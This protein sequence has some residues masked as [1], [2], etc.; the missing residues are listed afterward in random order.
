MKGYRPSM[1]TNS[2][3]ELPHIEQQGVTG[4]VLPIF[5]RHE[6][7]H[8]RHGWL[9]KGMDLAAEGVEMLS[10]NGAMVRLGV[11]KNMVNAIRYWC[12]AFKVIEPASSV[13]RSQS[14]SPTSFGLN[15]LRD[16]G[17]DPY[18]EDSGSLWLLH[19]HLL[20]P[21]CHAAAWYHA[22]YVFNRVEFT[23]DELFLAML[24][25]ARG[26]FQSSRVAESSLRKDAACIVRMYSDDS[27]SNAS[28]VETIS[29]PFAALRLIETSGDP[30]RFHF[31]VG[32]KPSL[33]AEIIA[34][35]CLDFMS[36]DSSRPAISPDEGRGAMTKSL[37]ALL[38]G[39]GSPGLAFKLTESALYSALESVSRTY[40]SLNIQD[41]GGILQIV[42]T[43]SPDAL[44]SRILGD[45]YTG[46]KPCAD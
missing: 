30:M 41:S 22:F 29:S 19:W 39:E 21:R 42:C 35:V 5:A 25:W 9:K 6:T 46:R 31:N 34:A 20:K 38:Y 32:L 12:R 1:T 17:W 24:E 3:L 43:E 14:F 4:E 45:Y 33:P 28:D 26:R 23:I 37:S 13:A 18:L 7:F 11:G 2:Q 16:A 8:P 40:E 36:L 27:S 10:A 44:K 15:L